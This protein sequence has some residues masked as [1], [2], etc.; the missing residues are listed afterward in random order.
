[1][2]NI[3]KLP[4]SYRH[5]RLVKAREMYD[6]PE[7]SEQMVWEVC[8]YLRG[9]EHEYRCEHCPRW[10]NHPKHGP[11]QK[12][13]FALAEEACRIVMAMIKRDNVPIV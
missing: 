3:V 1:M 4:V 9:I 11:I 2:T 8:P 13:C 10:E 6:Q 5:R 7:P 12:G